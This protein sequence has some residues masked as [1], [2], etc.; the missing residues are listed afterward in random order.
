[1]SLTPD[2]VVVDGGAE[3]RLH[4]RGGSTKCNPVAAAGDLFDGEALRV[5]PGGNRHHVSLG[6]AEAVAKLFGREPFVVIGRVA[7]LLLGKQLVKR[8][9]LLGAG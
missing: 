8:G 2:Q 5:E 1:M 9:L 4:L 3:C 7:V 6:Q